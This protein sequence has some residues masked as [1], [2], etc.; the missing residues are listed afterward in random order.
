MDRKEVIDE[1]RFRLTGGVLDLELDDSALNK[2]IDSAFREIQRY[3]DVSK[4]IMLPYSPCIDLKDLL[5]FHHLQ[6]E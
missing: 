1:I 6:L 5:R 2:V 4:F 3:I